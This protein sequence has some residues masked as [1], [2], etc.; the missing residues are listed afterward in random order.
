MDAAADPTDSG[1][2]SQAGLASLRNGAVLVQCDRCPAEL[3][4]P[5]EAWIVLHLSDGT[6]EAL[7]GP[8]A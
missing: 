1:F 4:V 7:R 2:S 8:R 5:D 3:G 6:H